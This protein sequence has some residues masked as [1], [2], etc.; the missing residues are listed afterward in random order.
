M[1]RTT[2][3]T[4]SLDW[5]A[6][7]LS[8]MSEQSVSPDRREATYDWAFHQ[9]LPGVHSTSTNRI[10]HDPSNHTSPDPS[11]TLLASDTRLSGTLRDPRTM[12]QAATPNVVAPPRSSTGTTATAPTNP[13]VMNFAWAS[14][15]NSDGPYAGAGLLSA[16]EQNVRHTARGGQR[17][18]NPSAAGRSIPSTPIST[19]HAVSGVPQSLSHDSAYPVVRGAHL[20]RELPTCGDIMNSPTRSSHPQADAHARR[21]M[22]PGGNLA[23]SFHHAESLP[24]GQEARREILNAPRLSPDAAGTVMRHSVYISASDVKA[25]ASLDDFGDIIR[26]LYLPPDVPKWQQLVRVA[27][28]VVGVVEESNQHSADGS[29]HHIVHAPDYVSPSEWISRWL[30]LQPQSR[31]AAS[32]AT[33]MHPQTMLYPADTT[34]ADWYPFWNRTRQVVFHTLLGLRSCSPYIQA[35]IDERH[36]MDPDTWAAWADDVMWALYQVLHHFKVYRQSTINHTHGVMS[37]PPAAVTMSHQEVSAR[38]TTNTRQSSGPPQQNSNAVMPPIYQQD[39]TTEL[40][41]HKKRTLDEPEE[42]GS[43]RWKATG[44]ERHITPPPQGAVPQWEAHKEDEDGDEEMSWDGRGEA[45]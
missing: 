29:L 17:G 35:P 38:T 36:I 12:V 33:R 26:K 43:K 25:Y 28:L 11:T 31:F 22:N 41:S 40:R 7:S 24:M 44:L 45:Y 39:L 14:T 32:D 6:H 1:N 19:D 30:D 15:R 18:N 34:L 27:V 10:S 2:R 20:S 4:P 5:D 16:N 37:D 21:Q 3:D 8:S 23:T 13:T 9:M 42:S